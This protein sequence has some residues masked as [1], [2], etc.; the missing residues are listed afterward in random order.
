MKTIIVLISCFFVTSQAVEAKVTEAEFRQATS[1]SDGYYIADSG[2]ADICDC[3]E[4]ILEDDAKI[5]LTF[6]SLNCFGIT[7]IGD[8][9]VEWKNE[10]CNYESQARLVGRLLT[11]TKTTSC[12]ITDKNL[13]SDDRPDRQTVVDTMTV[14]FTENGFN[15]EM[16][17]KVGSAA[18]TKTSCKMKKQQDFGEEAE[19]EYPE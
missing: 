3:S 13:L 19:P 18:P 10:R 4:F 6:S 8:G 17:R 14:T 2:S 15:Y 11:Y 7:N 9:K 1:F 12:I 5:G 16:G